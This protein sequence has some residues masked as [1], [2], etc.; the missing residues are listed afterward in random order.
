MKKLAAMVLAVVLCFSVAGCAS[1]V[2]QADYDAVVAERD[3]LKK[4]LE[5]ADRICEFKTKLAKYEAKVNAEYEHTL[6][7]IYVVEKISGV[8]FSANKELEETYN[9]VKSAIS[10]SQ[11]MLDISNKEENK[12]YDLGDVLNGESEKLVDTTYESWE[13]VF[14]KVIT[15][16]KALMQQN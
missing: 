15:A 12:K 2:S 13:N 9:G 6:F 14:E 11:N 7:F 4:E 3:Q 8:P 5:E 1:G 10:I 16:E